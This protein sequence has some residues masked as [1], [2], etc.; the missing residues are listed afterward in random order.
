MIDRSIP[1]CIC[2]FF[3]PTESSLDGSETVN[4]E[5]TTGSGKIVLEGLTPAVLECMSQLDCLWR[6]M[7]ISKEV[8]EKRL[9]TVIILAQELFLDMV[10]DEKEHKA[11]LLSSIEDFQKKLE[12]LCCELDIEP[13]K[14]GCVLF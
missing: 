4:D 3:S 2:A 14:V 7:G 9:E 8:L 12:V 1:S 13:Y 11:I 10:N 5:D 6:E